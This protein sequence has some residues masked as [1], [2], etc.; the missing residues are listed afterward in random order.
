LT[1]G[2]HWQLKFEIENLLGCIKFIHKT[3]VKIQKPWNNVAHQTWF[4]YKNKFYLKVSNVSPKVET[5]EE[6]R[7]RVCSL[8]RNTS[9]IKGCPRWG[10]GRM[11]SESI[12]HMSV[13]KP[14]NKLV[15]AW[16]GHFWCTDNMNIHKLTRF[17]TTWTWGK[18]PPSP[19]NI[20][21]D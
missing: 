3:L 9:E 1:K 21:C 13:H 10:L 5:L 4:N 14:N 2:L 6:E 11:T 12:I 8:L 19:Y 15:N 17:T 16:L 18:P 7:I 20:I